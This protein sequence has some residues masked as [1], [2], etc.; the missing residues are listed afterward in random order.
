[1]SL[2]TTYNEVILLF[3]QLTVSDQELSLFHTAN[4]VKKYKEKQ[5]SSVQAAQT[6]STAQTTQTES[7]E[8]ANKADSESQGHQQ[9]VQL[10]PARSTAS[11]NMQILEDCSDSTQDSRQIGEQIN[12]EKYTKVCTI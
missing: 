4:N 9:I 5:T 12:N 1:M 3:S 8:Q 7:A 10:S 2:F 11:E 6:G